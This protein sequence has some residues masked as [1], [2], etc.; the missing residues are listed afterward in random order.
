MNINLLNPMILAENYEKLIEWYIK[1]FDLTIKAKV[2]EGDEY[3][4]LEQAGKLVVGIA[5]ADEMGVKPPAPRNNTVIIQFLV[6]ILK[7][8]KFG[9]SKRRMSKNLEV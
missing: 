7:G 3:T 5:K 6:S 8:I 1:T 9:L 2:E 4:E